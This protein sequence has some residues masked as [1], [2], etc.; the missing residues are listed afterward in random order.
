MKSRSCSSTKNLSLS[1]T[2]E[3]TTAGIV[4]CIYLST[5]AG[6]APHVVTILEST[7]LAQDMLSFSSLPGEIHN[8]IFTLAIP[9]GATLAPCKTNSPIANADDVHTIQ[10]LDE[11]LENDKALP[12]IVFRQLVVSESNEYVYD[13]EKAQVYTALLQVDQ[14]TRQETAAQF[15]VLNHFV[16]PGSH[17]LQSF[18]KRLSMTTLS[19]VR[20]V[21]ISAFI[22][23]APIEPHPRLPPGARGLPIKVLWSWWRCL[24][25]CDNL[26]RLNV[27]LEA[28]SCDCQNHLFD[29]FEQHGR[30]AFGLHPT[31][32]VAFTSCQTCTDPEKSQHWRWSSESGSQEWQVI[33]FIGR[34]QVKAPQLYP[35]S[36]DFTSPGALLDGSTSPRIS[37]RAASLTSHLYHSSIISR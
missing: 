3:Q 7:V 13:E 37:N 4:V 6:G 22:I 21:S 9:Q 8:K 32:N 15:Y 19:F 33:H 35:K 30:E 20:N 5:V 12:T 27:S 23:I 14:K 31:I 2:S 26:Q 16:F 29:Q 25:K 28:T 24:G 1:P 18:L 11:V 34:T 17:Y 10:L 36:E